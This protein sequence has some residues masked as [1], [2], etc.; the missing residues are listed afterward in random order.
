[1]SDTQATPYN[2]DKSNPASSL[3]QKAGKG[4]G[5]FFLSRSK[6]F[7]TL[8]GHELDIRKMGI[9]TEL[10]SQA[11][12]NE[13]RAQGDV[14]KDVYK[15]K[16]GYNVEGAGKLNQVAEKG[17]PASLSDRGVEYTTPGSKLEKAAKG[18]ATAV[19]LATTIAPATRATQAGVSYAARSMARRVAAKRAARAAAA[20]APK[21]AA[22]PAAK[23]AAKSAAPKPA[24]KAAPKS[25]K[26]TAK[27]AAKKGAKK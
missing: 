7:N 13:M 24:Q 23:A 11:A 16:I 1:M 2:F 10:K 22:K 19:D 26:P 6:T 3:A 9:E 17:T 5:G 21:A 4:I 18:V 20:S 14:E 12:Q 15:S 8:L 25:P 27:P